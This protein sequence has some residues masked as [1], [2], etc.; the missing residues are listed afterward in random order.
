[1]LAAPQ[2]FDTSWIGSLSLLE[3]QIVRASLMH[4]VHD[5]DD[6]TDDCTSAKAE[7]MLKSLDDAVNGATPTEFA[8]LIPGEARPVLWASMWAAIKNVHAP[9]DN[10]TESQWILAEAYLEALTKPT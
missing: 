9:Q 1:M 7:H 2:T 5:L 4:S 10:L 3:Q 8:A 6:V